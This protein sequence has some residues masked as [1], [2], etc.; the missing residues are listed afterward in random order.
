[1]FEKSELNNALNSTKQFINEIAPHFGIG[2]TVAKDIARRAEFGAWEKRDQYDPSTETLDDWMQNFGRA[3]LYIHLLQHK[4][5]GLQD[6]YDIVRRRIFRLFRLWRLDPVGVDDVIQE[7]HDKVYN[8]FERYNSEVGSLAAWITTIAQRRAYNYLESASK[9]LKNQVLVGGPTEYLPVPEI[10]FGASKEPDHAEAIATA[11]SNRE[12]VKRFSEDLT[13]LFTDLEL[14][15][16]HLDRF[17]HVHLHFDGNIQD[18]ARGM[19]TTQEAVRM[20]ARL[21]RRIAQTMHHT[22]QI[23][24]SGQEPFLRDCL[25]D[26]EE[27]SFMRAY[28]PFIREH[29]GFNISAAMAVAQEFDDAANTIRDYFRQIRTMYRAAQWVFTKNNIT[30]TDDYLL[31]TPTA[32]APEILRAVE[33]ARSSE[34]TTS[35][36]LSSLLNDEQL[37]ADLSKKLG[38]PVTDEML[39]SLIGEIAKARPDMIN[40]DLDQAG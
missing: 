14:P 2:P 20:S 38:A 32:T 37:R 6:A 31:D 33:Q 34:P 3:A 7:T 35:P 1:M 30:A 4:S 11:V 39:Q 8:T 29:G 27:A 12:Q 22:Q 15:Q 36:Q 18:A 23:I 21:S 5:S 10:M 28:E 19:K 17:L 40:N 16:Q 9:D 13:E 24:E 25:P 26:L